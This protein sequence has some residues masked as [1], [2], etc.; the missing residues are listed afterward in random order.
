[1]KFK[2]LILTV[3]LTTST[4]VSA[5]VATFFEDSFESYPFGSGLPQP[6]GLTGYL[7]NER[8]PRVVGTKY[9]VTAFSGE[10]MVEIRS[11]TQGGEH[12]LYRNTPNQSGVND[13]TEA[14]VALCIPSFDF[15]EQ[16]VETAIRLE[17]DS[18]I[19]IKFDVRGGGSFNYRLGDDVPVNGSVPLAF[20]RWH[21]FR[22]RLDWAERRADFS[23]DGLVFYTT[24]IPVKNNRHFAS[25]EFGTFQPNP[26]IGEYTIL[27]GSP[28][29]L[30]DSY[31]VRAV[32]EP[33]TSVSLIFLLGVVVRRNSKSEKI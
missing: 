29:A 10:K 18:Y 7:E 13:I 12:W 24:D 16:L 11:A 26:L 4:T 31:A 23:V 28:G 2:E 6:Y 5:Q 15:R 1:M 25:L 9:G 14:S 30:F 17:N 3:A 32:P 21:H 20:D 27:D 22:A 8:S 19:R 33:I